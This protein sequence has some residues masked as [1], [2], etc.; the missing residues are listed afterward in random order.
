M[1]ENVLR[2]IGYSEPLV[3]Q[4]GRL[5]QELSRLCR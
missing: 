2:V 5:R 1:T 4:A 3:E